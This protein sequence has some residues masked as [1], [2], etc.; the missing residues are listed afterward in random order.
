MEVYG[1]EA[2]PAACGAIYSPKKEHPSSPEDWTSSIPMGA[3]A[4]CGVLCLSGG[5]LGRVL[6]NTS[7]C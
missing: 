1:F 2:E 6:F 5:H 3:L 4:G 7:I